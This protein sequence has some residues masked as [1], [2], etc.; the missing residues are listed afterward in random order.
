MPNPCKAYPAAR[1]RIVRCIKPT[2][3]RQNFKM[4]FVY[5]ALFPDRGA[6]GVHARAEARCGKGGER[7]RATGTAERGT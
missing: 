6:A 3:A 5:A 2:P 4:E 7:T 1:L